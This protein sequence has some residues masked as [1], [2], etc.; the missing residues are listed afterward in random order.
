M[1]KVKGLASPEVFFQKPWVPF[2]HP[3]QEKIMAMVHRVSDTVGLLL[4][5]LT[6]PFG[7][8]SS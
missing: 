2:M 4:A 5:Y 1:G 3:S 6:A 7:P 8:F